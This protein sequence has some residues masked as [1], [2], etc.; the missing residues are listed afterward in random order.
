MGSGFI[1]HSIYT[2]DDFSIK[3]LLGNIFFL[4][5]SKSYKGNWFAPYGDNGPLWSLSFEMFF[6]FFFPV[7]IWAMLKILKVKTLKEKTNRI[8]L[9]STLLISLVCILINNKI[10]FP[11]IA[12]AAL[13]YFW[14]CGFFL[15]DLYIEKRVL[16]NSNFL[17][18]IILLLLTAILLH[19]KSS[20][21]LYK[22]FCGSVMA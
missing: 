2:N 1:F 11:Y 3:N 22:L 21:G 19:L 6:Y 14:F 15:A 13:F 20:A 18:V 10:F 7:F 12:F 4:Q 16:L 8:V 17:T 9:C 5:C